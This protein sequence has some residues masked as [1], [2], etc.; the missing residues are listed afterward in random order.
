MPLWHGDKVTLMA[1]KSRGDV[2][3][4]AFTLGADGPRA[5]FQAGEVYPLQA[6]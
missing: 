4:K 3:P 2:G 5:H 1:L 6:Y